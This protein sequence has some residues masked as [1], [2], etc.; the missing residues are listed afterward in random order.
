MANYNPSAF[1]GG[2]L[3]G[4]NID[5]TNDLLPFW[6]NSASTVN[7][8][9]RV[10]PNEFRNFIFGS[11]SGKTGY[12]FRSAGSGAPLFD[13]KPFDP[14]KVNWMYSTFES[15]SSLPFAIASSASGTGAQ[16]T[17]GPSFLE[18]YGLFGV[19]V[20]QTQS[21]DGYASIDVGAGGFTIQNY[22]AIGVGISGMDLPDVTNDWSVYVGISYMNSGGS[23]QYSGPILIG[24]RSNT[25]WQLAQYKDNSIDGTTVDTGLPFAV[26]TQNI[27][28]WFD[29]VAHASGVTINGTAGTGRTGLT[30]QTSPSNTRPSVTMRR[31]AGS[32]SK[33]VNIDWVYRYSY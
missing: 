5:G 11:Q 6:D 18:Y 27:E 4:A 9:V 8:S 19:C 15:G 28:V 29:N 21:S 25:N 13:L 3:T 33:Q 32:G 10:T 24:S 30:A 16:V 22:H 2:A 31:S 17:V 26:A 20:L 1:P 7:R 23:I 14:T 12:N